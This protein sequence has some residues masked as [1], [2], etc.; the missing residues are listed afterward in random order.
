M[1]CSS[2]SSSSSSSGGGMM[3]ACCMLDAF[4]LLDV[5]LAVAALARGQYMLPSSSLHVKLS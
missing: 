5:Q 4:A 1:S 3:H 2:S